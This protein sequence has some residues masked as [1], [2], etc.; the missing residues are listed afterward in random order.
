[1]GILLCAFVVVIVWNVAG[2][3]QPYSIQCAGVQ[4][5]SEGESHHFLNS[6]NARHTDWTGENT[7]A[8]SISGWH[9]TGGI[10]SGISGQKIW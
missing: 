10:V 2:Y 1:M 9:E 3:T 4:I 5:V 8:Q 7:K 6:A